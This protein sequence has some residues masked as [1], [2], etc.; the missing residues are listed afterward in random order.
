[1]NEEEMT[2][3][4]PPI[5]VVCSNLASASIPQPISLADVVITDE[6]LSRRIHT[7]KARVEMKAM[8]ELA[9]L[10]AEG[11]PVL[12]K[13]LAQMAIELCNAGSGGISMLEAGQD[14][15]LFRWRALAGELEKYEGGSTPRDWS[16]CGQCLKAA[17]A[18]LY[19]YPARFFTYFQE[20]DTTIVE[21]LV[22]PM[23]MGG[24]AIGTIWI[25]SHDE[26]RRFN[27]EHVRIMTSLGS[28]VSAE[29]RLSL[30]KGSDFA[31]AAKGAR[32]VVWEELVHRIAGGDC[33]A[34][35]ALIDETKPV[36]FGRALRLLG[37][38]ADA[39]E[40]T[41]DVYSHVWRIAGRYDPQRSGV[42]AWLLNIVHTRGIDLLR[43]RARQHR[44]EEALY[45]ECSNALDPKGQTACFETKSHIRQ[46]LQALP[47]EQR[48]AI[49]LVYFGGY[50]MAELAAHLDLP[51]GTVKSRVRYG[52]IRLRRLMATT[53]TYSP[54]FLS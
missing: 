24:Q 21:G 39:E 4:S 12:L 34:L 23:Y 38:R 7:V 33:S 31:Y 16:P 30:N 52:L 25:I 2:L 36:V 32:S 9:E 6:L 1:M 3:L 15:E 35:A 11:A 40:V 27:A 37:L 13:R 42:L 41:M 47:R 29:L 53:E 22:I 48:H 45:F 18:M 5:E 50:S 20:V 51:L 28:F 14:G 10:L 8:Y 19:A 26:R 54:P 46:A 44:S 17:K 49:E 43:S